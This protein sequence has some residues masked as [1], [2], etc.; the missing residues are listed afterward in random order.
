MHSPL[1]KVFLVA[2]EAKQ[3][4]HVGIYPSLA[5]AVAVAAH[6][7]HRVW[8]R[9]GDPTFEP[10]EAK[11]I[12]RKQAGNA[13]N[14][15]SN[16]FVL[17]GLPAHAGIGLRKKILDVLLP[18]AAAGIRETI[19]SGGPSGINHS[20]SRGTT[21]GAMSLGLASASVIPSWCACGVDDVL[22]CAT[23]VIRLESSHSRT[24]EA[25]RKSHY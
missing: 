14:K 11:K 8:R 22:L 25:C 16:G 12:R 3:N 17:I 7:S 2:H 20:R 5:E 23:E 19:E 6:E 18:A 13:N 4:A 21:S 9:A 1:I 24:A 15:L 10:F